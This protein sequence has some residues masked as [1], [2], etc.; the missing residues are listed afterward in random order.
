MIKWICLQS[1]IFVWC[2]TDNDCP[3]FSKVK[4]NRCSPF[5]IR[6]KRK[7]KVKLQFIPMIDKNRISPS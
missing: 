2:K 4:E 6:K 7:R 3:V 5:K 1:E